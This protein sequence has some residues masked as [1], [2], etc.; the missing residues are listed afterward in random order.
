MIAAIVAFA[1][2][3]APAAADA[4]D[5]EQAAAIAVVDLNE[6]TVEQLSGL[7]GIGPKKAGA[8]IAYREQHRF[9]RVTQLLEVRGIGKKTL[10]RLRPHVRVKPP[11]VVPAATA[12]A[13][14]G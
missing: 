7:P 3:G 12:A 9:T 10:E 13:P 1:L 5:A 2:T 4:R 6:A 8:I 14:P 11:P